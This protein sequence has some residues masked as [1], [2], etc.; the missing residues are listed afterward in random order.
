MYN[1]SEAD[2]VINVAVAVLS[3]T[4]SQ[5]VV[6][7]MYTMDSSALCKNII[8]SYILPNVYLPLTSAPEDY[9]PVNMTLTFD[10]ASS[11]LVIPVRI[12]NDAIDEDD[13]Q[14]ISR[15]ELEPVE[16]DLPNVQ[17]DPAQ[18]TLTIVDDDGELNVA[19]NTKN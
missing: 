3:G 7:R 14:L 17:V 8:L 6:V 2:E 9:E 5:E 4:L 16:G 1:G 18:A 11:R 19:M 10:G 15:L 12:V 13:E